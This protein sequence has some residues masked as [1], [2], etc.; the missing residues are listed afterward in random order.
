MVIYNISLTEAIL[1]SEICQ[2]KLI[3]LL[4]IRRKIGR[5]TVF[6]KKMQFDN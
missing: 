1:F 2:Q 6:L 3:K 5:E 4:E